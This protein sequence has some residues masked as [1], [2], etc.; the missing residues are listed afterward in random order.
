MKS[1]G[2][3]LIGI[4]VSPLISA[5]VE[6]AAYCPQ[7]ARYIN[8][9]MT[10]DEVLEACG[11]PMAKQSP[12]VPVTQ[13]VPVKQFIYTALNTGS[14]YPGLNPA[15]YT[16]WSIPSGTRGIGVE[17]DVVNDRVASVKI[18]GSNTNAMTVCGN[19]SVQIGDAVSRVYTACGSPARVN[20][21]FV[22]QVIP[23]NSK[24]EVWIYQSTPYQ[25]P[26]SLTFVNGK[27]QSIN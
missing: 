8:V 17:V 6:A 26:F 25:A 22:N 4:I 13:R 10:Q 2:L 3:M 23:S 15:F 27:L 9:G 11:Q 20:N 14:V 24:P 19:N 18:N 16:Q 21:T 12:N 1:I 7:H 5:T